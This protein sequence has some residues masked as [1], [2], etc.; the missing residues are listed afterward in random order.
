[1]WYTE[2]KTVAAACLL[3]HDTGFRVHRKRIPSS[4]HTDS[5]YM[6][7]SRVKPPGTETGPEPRHSLS[8]NACCERGDV[9]FW[10]Q[11]RTSSILV[12][13]QPAWSPCHPPPVRE[14]AQGWLKAG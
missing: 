4:E 12:V 5:E 6:L 9:K 10:I 14:G 3:I 1:M 11:I 8:G 7:L 2:K 13:D